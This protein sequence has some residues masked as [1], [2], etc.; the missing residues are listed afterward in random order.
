MNSGIS[1]LILKAEPPWICLATRNVA[2]ILRQAL[3]LS[4]PSNGRI[5]VRWLRGSKMRGTKGLFD[6]FSAALQFPY[7]FGENWN[8]F[9]ECIE[10]LEG[11]DAD[12]YLL[13]ILNSDELLVDTEDP[14]VEIEHLFSKLSYAGEEW[15]KP[16]NQGSSSDRPSK[17][18]HVILHV[19][20]T[21]ASAF[22][23]RLEGAGLVLPEIPN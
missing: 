18:F 9:D 19:D 20:E 13:I 11:I 6:E 12:G 22:R 4:F 5:A 21:K 8:A 3:Q 17:S 7:Y 15:A 2:S 14:E 16:I 23:N 10:E 1:N